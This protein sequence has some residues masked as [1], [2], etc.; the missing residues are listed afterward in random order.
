LRPAYVVLKEL[1]EAIRK[2]NWDVTV[3][4]TSDGLI[5]WVEGGRREKPIY[6]FA[7]DIGTT[8][9][10][11][12]LVDLTS[13]DMVAKAAMTNPQ[14]TFGGDV[15]SRISYALNG[16]D[17][18]AQLQ[19]VVV[20]AT[21]SLIQECCAQAHAE[22]RDVFHVVIVGN[23]VMH[24]IFLG[25]TPKYVGLSP[26]TP[27]FRNPFQIYAKEVGIAA[28]PGCV[29]D[30]LPCV[31]GFV[32]ADAV[33][34]ILAT[35][36]HTSSALAL[37]VDIGTNTEIVLGKE[38]GL[39]CCSSPSGPAFEGAQ[40]KNG[41][42]AEVGA[43]ERVWVDPTTLEAEY[44]TIGGKKPRGICGSGAID[45]IASMRRTGIIDSEGRFNSET[46][47]ER[48]RRVDGMAEY[49]LAR[50]E[51][52]QIG[53]DIS[54]TQRDIE[55]IKL[56]KAA[57][58]TGI[59]ILARHL[60]IQTDDIEKFFV[61]GAFGTYVDPHSAR[62]IGMY[63]D[64]PLGRISFVGNAAGSGARMAL[65]SKHKR[66]EAQQIAETIK[67]IELA[68][69]PDFQKEFIDSLYIPHKRNAEL[70]KK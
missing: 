22:F 28:N 38:G 52:T 11:G 31:A 69:Q 6:G 43:I 2:G 20:E 26:Y 32:G 48:I 16:L 59:V 25:I 65:L 58:Y 5:T 66:K 35:Q 67:Y 50:K 55:E 56:A 8:K 41:M 42:R 46:G 40:I 19:R 33:A 60:K 12:Y 27:V 15:I 14:V 54:I 7:I 9:M 64:I 53:R 51:E 62:T 57:V 36:M 1:P 49:V 17:Q 45:A 18:L 4:V 30:A 44:N 47:S 63:P 23:T 13:G 24:H 39:L 37:L 21:N 70:R 10:A 34:D 3:T 68:A 29:L 61:A